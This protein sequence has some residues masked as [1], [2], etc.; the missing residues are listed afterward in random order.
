MPRNQP[1]SQNAERDAAQPM[2]GQPRS[3]D[4][5]DSLQQPDDVPSFL[6][7]RELQARDPEKADGRGD[8]ADDDDEPAEDIDEVKARKRPSGKSR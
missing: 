1:R 6:T 7:A 2:A 3:D 8:T 5:E 4:D